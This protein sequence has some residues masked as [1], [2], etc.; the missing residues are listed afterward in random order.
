MHPADMIFY[1]AVS[2]PE[3]PAIIQPNLVVS[4]RE[5]AEAVQAISG[6]VEHYGFNPQEPVAV[7]VHQ[8]LHKLAVCFALLQCGI[9]AAPISPGALP[10]LRPSGIHNVIFT[11]EGQVLAGGRNIRFEESWL[12]TDRKLSPPQSLESGAL[13]ADL[14]FFVLDRTG[15]PKKLIIP[16]GALAAEIKMLPFIGD[17]D[18]SRVLLMMSLNSPTGFIRAALNLY[19]GRA[20][21]FAG[22][23]ESQ[24]LLLN[25]FN[26]EK[27][28]CSAREAFDFVNAI[29]NKAYELDPLK[30][31]AIG[32]GHISK[33]LANSVRTRLCR[34]LVTRY[35]SI[36]AGPIAYANYSTIAGVPNAVGFVLPGVRVEIVGDDDAPVDI[37]QK[38]R[39]RCRSEFYDRVFSANKSGQEA[40]AGLWCYTGDV[41]CLTDNDLLCIFAAN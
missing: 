24:L 27:I 37:N 28:E 25:T 34:N 2:N 39:L 15:R 21:C 26:I 32:G 20:V 14:N 10:H 1:R 35:H 17:I 9:S 8:P 3:Q 41:A 36:E 40:E 38:G 29:D 31:V 5:F 4:Y 7:S 22:T 6:R 13:H 19:A 11:G 30:E 12:K 33:E 23:I 18:H 16:S